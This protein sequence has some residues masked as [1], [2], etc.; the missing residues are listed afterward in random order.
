MCTL[1][2]AVQYLI[3]YSLYS[4][5]SFCYEMFPAFANYEQ[6]NSRYWKPTIEGESGAYGNTQAANSNTWQLFK[7]TT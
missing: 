3:Y 6:S 2:K 7:E 1:Y 4:F 5:S